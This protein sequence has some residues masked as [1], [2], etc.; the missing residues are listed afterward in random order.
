MATNIHGELSLDD[1]RA[2]AEGSCDWESWIGPDES[3]RW[4]NSAGLAMSGYS[5]LECRAMSRF[6]WPLVLKDDH[7]TFELFDHFVGEQR[8]GN[9]LPVRIVRRDGSLIWMT[10]SWRPIHD[11]TGAYLGVRLSLRDR[12]W[13]LHNRYLDH[14]RPVAIELLAEIMPAARAG[15]MRRVYHLMTERAARALG[16]ARVGIWMFDEQRQSLIAADRFSSVDYSHLE[17]SVLSLA[18]CPRYRAA[19]T[20]DQL[21]VAPDA[22]SDP[23]TSELA[24]SYL[25]P[26]GIASMLDAPIVRGGRTI[27]VICHEHVGGTRSWYETELAFVESL[28]DFLTLALYANEGAQLTE[29]NRMLA[30]IVEVLP[31]PVVTVDLD[32]NPVYLNKAA[33]QTHEPIG[34]SEVTEFGIQNISKSYSPQS[35]Q[36]RKEVIV[37]AALANGYWRG[38]VRL[39]TMQGV[40]IPVWQ[41]M[42]AHQDQ[43]GELKLLTSILRDLREQKAVETRL[44]ESEAALQVRVADRTRRIEQLHLDLE[45]FSATV[46]RDFLV[47]QRSI[48]ESVVRMR[49]LIAALLLHSRTVRR[50][51]L[52]TR[53][54]AGAAVRQEIA[55]L[56]STN[57]EGPL[58]ITENIEDQEI[59]ADAEFFKQIVR[60]LIDN[61]IKF[62]AAGAAPLV[63]VELRQVSAGLLLTVTDNGCGFDMKDH[64]RIFG[65]FRRLPHACEY[66]G[67][68][69]GLAIVAQAAERMGGRVWAQSTLG[70][71]AQFN[72]L[73]PTLAATA[74]R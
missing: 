64:D 20:G 13:S 7:I 33:Y 58:R 34:E 14:F 44:R 2:I 21:V 29:R 19:L 36:Y 38:E 31:D 35:L 57:P 22:L 37:P 72:F 5:A 61:A 47:P 74:T 62:S 24:D 45:A 48:D 25:R 73:I 71:G 70:Q 4:M 9:D 27:G 26:L 63:A 54:S 41:T 56:H 6:P 23:V 32:G 52:N 15:D 11:R 40:E 28:S 39:A 55:D 69:I 59:S 67:T 49:T 16:V 43:T 42:V 18:D 1:Y 30:S 53:F 3:L 65:M 12:S 60:S 50:E 66:P 10:A 17:G 68:G 8:P 51:A 46:A